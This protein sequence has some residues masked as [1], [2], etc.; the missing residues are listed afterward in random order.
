M[1]GISWLDE[2]VKDSQEDICSTEFVSSKLRSKLVSMLV[3][4]Q[5]DLKD[6]HELCKL[7]MMFRIKMDL[8]NIRRETN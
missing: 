4:L 6:L 5:M 1:W 2:D 7:L 3:S 8:N